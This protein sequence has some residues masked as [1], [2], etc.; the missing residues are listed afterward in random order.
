MAGAPPAARPNPARTTFQ[1]VVGTAAPFVEA[2]WTLPHDSPVVVSWAFI[3]WQQPAP[4]G[5]ARANRSKVAGAI[6]AGTRQPAPDQYAALRIMPFLTYEMTL[7]AASAFMHELDAVGAFVPAYPT[8]DEWLAALP[9]HIN[10]MANPDLMRLASAHFYETEN[11]AAR[12]AAVPA[13]LAYL[14]AT[15]LGTLAYAEVDEGGPA[16]ATSTLSRAFILLGSKDTRTERADESAWVRIAAERVQIVLLRSL[17][18]TT[19]SASGLASTFVTTLRDVQLPSAFNR[20]SAEAMHALT[21]FEAGFAHAQGSSA[22]VRSVETTRILRAGHVFRAMAPVLARFTSSSEAWVEIER[23]EASLLPATFSS[24]PTLVKL[25]SL[26]TQ[27]KA[28]AWQSFLSHAVVANPAIAGS[29]LVSAMITSHT[30][31]AAAPASGGAGPAAL[32]SAADDGGAGGV[33]TGHA[34]GAVRDTALADALLADEARSALEKAATETGVERVETLMQSGSTLCMRSILLQESWLQNKAT[35]LSFASLDEPYLCPYFASTVCEDE[36]TGE[37][38]PRLTGY[39]F[40][41]KALDQMRSTKW[42]DLPLLPIAVAVEMLK[43]GAKIRP[44]Q[45][46]EV[47]TVDACLRLVR[48]TGSRLFFSLGLDLSPREGKSFTDG[49]DLQ[50]KAVTFARTLPARECAEWLI[51]LDTEFTSSFLNGA[52]LHYHSKLRSGRPDHPQAEISEFVP[53]KNAYFINVQARL[54]RAE[55]I[56]DLRA[57]VPSLFGSDEVSLAG[58]SSAPV[59]EPD[60]ERRGKNKKKGKDKKRPD[61][62]KEVGP[63]SKSGMAYE[64]SASEFFHT[65]V[66]FKSKEI[67]DKYSLDPDVCLAVLLTKKSGNDALQLCPDHAGHGDMSAKCHKR[68]KGFDLNYIYKHY[69]RKATAAELKVANWSPKK[70]GKA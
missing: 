21:D 18:A 29:D 23:L 12:G 20:T 70:K 16:P 10:K 22:E 19:A 33:G 69:T 7:V 64:V 3:T 4:P 45:P 57:A 37:V 55:P 58:T 35:A 2:Q 9:N 40:P 39:V 44:V 6:M 38:H 11:Y 61:H 54:K 1:V 31:I 13:E 30:D 62:D 50:L 65:G 53:A 34:Y 52:G 68:P 32:P 46:I 51:F 66:V 41:D 15:S 63:G 48:E 25:S 59:K 14:F 8:M 17:H 56:A 24:S 28:T 47:Y 49:V 5:R 43:T 67:S 42:A 26:D 60:D 36:D 27:L